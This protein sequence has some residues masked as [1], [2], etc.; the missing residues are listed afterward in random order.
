MELEEIDAVRAKKK[1]RLP[2]VLTQAEVGALLQGLSTDVTALVVRLLYGCGLRVAEAL[3]LRIK[4]VDLA[5]GKLEVRGG[6]GDK[7][8]VITL[9]KGLMPAL[10]EH[11]S[12]IQQWH[13]A[14]RRDGVPGVELP[15]AVAQ[16]NP[17]AGTSWPWFWFF[18]GKSLSTDPRSGIVRR[19]H[20]HEIGITREL[21]RA[22]ALA[23]LPRRVTAH[24][25]RH[26]FATHL[27]LRGVDIRSVQDLLGHA[28]VST[29]EIYT[30]LARAMRW[31]I[32]SPLDDL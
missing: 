30:E 22:A 19:H 7:D 12:R 16:K 17:S 28:Q 14:D 23:N 1:K 29:T 20:L 11:R 24:V 18:P 21:A 9:P 5:G 8:R 3:S 25:L 26:S 10:L 2:V 6:K 15:T 13:E 31:E 27:L 4:D 32:T